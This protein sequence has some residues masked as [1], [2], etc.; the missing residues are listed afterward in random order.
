MIELPLLPPAIFFDVK[1]AQGKPV[2]D[3]ARIIITGAAAAAAQS[4]SLVFQSNQEARYQGTQLVDAILEKDIRD[5]LEIFGDYTP[6]QAA[7][8]PLKS[9]NETA[10]E[11]YGTARDSSFGIF[12]TNKII[13]VDV[14][15]LTEWRKKDFFN[16]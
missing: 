3:T 4:Q 16:V 8:F 1:S 5:A 13:F 7:A 10:W 14:E 2:S 12:A 11:F 9:L 15:F 6:T